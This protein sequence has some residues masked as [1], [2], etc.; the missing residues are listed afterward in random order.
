METGVITEIRNDKGIQKEYIRIYEVDGNKYIVAYECDKIKLVPYAC[1]LCL[2]SRISVKHAKDPNVRKL[3]QY[4]IE[5]SR[6]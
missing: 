2:C 4:I 5:N 1:L 3:E 6:H